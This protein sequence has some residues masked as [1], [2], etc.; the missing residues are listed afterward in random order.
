MYVQLAQSLLQLQCIL[1][2][3]NMRIKSACK[4]TYQHAHVTCM[5]HE[6]HSIR[7]ATMLELNLCTESVCWSM[8]TSVI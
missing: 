6:N 5:V 4:L 1:D 2:S 3:F 7:W 8:Y